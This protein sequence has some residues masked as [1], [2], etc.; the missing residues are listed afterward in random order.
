MVEH[1]TLDVL[2]RGGY[3]EGKTTSDER[4]QYDISE[5]FPLLQSDANLHTALVEQAYHLADALKWLH[6]GLT[7]VGCSQDR[8]LAHMDLTPYNILIQGNPQDKSTPAGTWMIS[9]FGISGFHEKTN[10]PVHAQDGTICNVATSLTR[11]L[12]DDADRG[13]G[14]FQPPEVDLERK[15]KQLRDRRLH[16]YRLCDVWSFGCILSEI[17]AFALGKREGVLNFRDKRLQGNDLNFFTFVNFPKEPDFAVTAANTQLKKPI[18]DWMNAML[19]TYADSWVSVF[20]EVL[21]DESLKPCPSDRA[22]IEDVMTSLRDVLTKLN[23]AEYRGIATLR[24]A[25]ARLL[26][27]PDTRTNVGPDALHSPS[28]RPIGGMQA[29]SGTAAAATQQG[30]LV[31]L[32]SSPQY[33]PGRPSVPQIVVGGAAQHGRMP[34]TPDSIILGSD[35]PNLPNANVQETETVASTDIQSASSLPL[36]T[37]LGNHRQISTMD[38]PFNSSSIVRVPG[39]EGEHIKSVALDLNGER[40]ALL[41]K[42]HVFV[43]MTMNPSI[44]DPKIPISA[45]VHWDTIMLTYPLLAI[46]GNVSKEVKVSRVSSLTISWKSG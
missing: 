31:S 3:Q 32:G 16:D 35:S 8:Y 39:I 9:D 11:E 7:K 28:N 5:R 42:T 36:S 17:L 44:S 25:S 40:I 27:T 33:H 34:D 4:H 1:G 41:S 18:T 37:D 19:K 45:G 2:L 30:S 21:R 46:K 15:Y 43:F 38:G 12:R 20:V 10:E 22:D 14:S 26:A 23:A 29:S 6:H 24:P 13:H